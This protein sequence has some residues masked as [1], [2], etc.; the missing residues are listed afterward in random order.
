MFNPVENNNKKKEV[1][2]QFFDQAIHKKEC[3]PVLLEATY[4]WHSQPMQYQ[5]KTTDTLKEGQYE[6]LTRIRFHLT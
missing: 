6:D 5:C 4:A 2:F 3:K 1:Q